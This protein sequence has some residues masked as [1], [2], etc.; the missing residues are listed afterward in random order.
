V[1]YACTNEYALTVAVPVT[2]QGQFAGVAAADVLASRLERR[3]L[4]ALRTLRRPAVL[5][6]AGGRVVASSS[7]EFASGMRVRLPDRPATRNRSTRARPRPPLDWH[8]LPVP[9]IR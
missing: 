8:L 2:V 4:P 5:L 6:N 7:P 9:G 1:G 3:L